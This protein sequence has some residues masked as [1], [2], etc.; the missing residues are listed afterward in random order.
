MS[1]AEAAITCK[2]EP[3]MILEAIDK[4]NIDKENS[5]FLGDSESDAIAGERA[6][7]KT[8]LIGDFSENKANFV[9][10]NYSIQLINL[11][12]AQIISR[13]VAVCLTGLRKK[14]L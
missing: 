11:K 2:P 8:I 12:K 6:G 3:G 13:H 1:G 7:I 5:F 10:S 14:M 4:W 9:F